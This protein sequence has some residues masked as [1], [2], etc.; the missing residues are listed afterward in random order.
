MKLEQAIEM[1][2]L[3]IDYQIEYWKRRAKYWDEQGDAEMWDNA[4][5][6]IE[7]W[8]KVKENVLEI[9]KGRL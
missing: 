1:A 5:K 6:Q 3:S 9:Q 8:R 7:N 2:V 4:T